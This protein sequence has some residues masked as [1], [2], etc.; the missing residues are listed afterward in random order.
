MS[1][2]R[3]RIVIVT[4]KGG[5][6]KSTVAAALGRKAAKS[7][8]RT[9]IAEPS[10]AAR[11]P[12]IFG[13]TAQGYEPVRLRKRLWSISITPEKALEDYVVQ[14]I[15]FRRLYQ[16]VF[17]NRVMGPFVD[18][19]PGL[20]DSVQLGKIFDLERA[21]DRAEW[22]LVIVDA[23]AT[24]HGLTLLASATTMMDLTRAGPMYEGVRLVHER[25]DD[26]AITALVLVALPE[27]MPVAET[28]DLWDRL[29]ERQPLVRMCVLNGVQPRP[30]P[31]SVDWPHARAALATDAS[32]AVSEAIGL[33]DAWLARSQV[34]DRARATLSDRVGVPL[35]ELPRLS[36]P[37]T[38]ASD[39]DKLGDSLLAVLE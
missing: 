34:Q 25:L 2:T 16:M 36:Q 29:A 37:I 17:R 30:F 22:D 28:L 10:G 39:L 33:T 31:D 23:P 24:G 15:K 8:L 27:E 13:V 3:P 9:I 1:P 12:E 38:R 7:G 20:R 32:P 19:V 4:G 26:P 14:Q 11:M 6:G 35:A 5:V 18:G 21:G